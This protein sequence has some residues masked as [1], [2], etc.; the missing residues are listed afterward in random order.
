MNEILSILKYWHK[1]EHFAPYE[2]VEINSENFRRIAVD[3]DVSLPWNEVKDYERLYT[4]YLGVFRMRETVKMIEAKLGEEKKPEENPNFSCICMFRI[5]NEVEYCPGTFRISALPW[6]VGKIINDQWE[7]EWQDEF[8][9]FEDPIIQKICNQEDLDYG[10]FEDIKNFITSKL[11]WEVPFCD[12]WLFIDEKKIEKDDSGQKFEIPVDEIIESAKLGNVPERI[13]ETEEVLE[14]EEKFDIDEELAKK[15]ELL[16][17]FY[18]RDIERLIDEA[19]NKNYGN[20]FSNFILGNVGKNKIDIENDVVE[21][22][23]VLSPKNFPLGRWPSENSLSLMQQVAVNLSKSGIADE[24]GLFSVNGPPGTGKTTLLRDIIASII[25]DRA[26]ILAQLDHP[27]DAFVKGEIVKLPGYELLRIHHLKEEF[28]NFG[29]IVAS[30]NNGAVQNITQELPVQKAIPKKY[31]GNKKCH[32]FS[33]QADYAF[34]KKIRKKCWGFISAVLGNVK[35]CSDFANSFWDVYEKSEK[36]KSMRVLLQDKKLKLPSWSKAVQSFKD[37]LSEVKNV[38]DKLENYRINLDLKDSLELEIEDLE[39]KRVKDEFQLKEVCDEIQNT[40]KLIDITNDQI[41]DLL[42]EIEIYKS[43]IKW[44]H[45]WFRQWKK[46][47]ILYGVV[48]E[49][50]SRQAQ[51][52]KTNSELKGNLYEFESKS[53]KI[54]TEIE[55][56][57]S[58]INENKIQ[59]NKANTIHAEAKTLLGKNFPDSDYWR[60]FENNQDAQINC[61]WAYTDF[62]ELREQLFLEAL[63]LHKVFVLNSDAMKVHNMNLFYNLL[64]RKLSFEDEKKYTSDLFQSFFL[65]VPVISTTFASVARLLKYVNREEIAWLMIDEAGQGT[66]QSAVGA[67]WRAKRTLVIG[68]PLQIEPVVTTPNN[69]LKRLRELYSVPQ[70]FADK[71]LS[72]QRLGDE[73]NPYGTKRGSLWIGCPLRVHRRCISPMFEIA[74]TIAYKHKMICATKEP[75]N[76]E[77]IMFLPSLNVKELLTLHDRLQVC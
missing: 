23:K 45:K 64:K 76:D 57:T 26:C 24:L 39:Q 22:K 6:A 2:P 52:L 68:D 65:L 25:V 11:G 63:Q 33:V 70:Q 72:I 5:S 61:P 8:K 73:I 12:T 32:Y 55:K 40:K 10:A 44:Y 27:D 21:I 9:K 56:I 47:K 75:E 35:N 59:L 69:V 66:P 54:K 29:I 20:G 19:K 1:I 77:F 16:N 30:N 28:R 53:H 60:D 67:I 3:S 31:S 58:N 46:S 13:E 38:V 17:S 41:E 36:N 48:D 51:K 71:E 7:D 37:K 14:E 49:A 74:N 18:A 4:I 50:E 15:N 42:K 62:N 43:R 34:E